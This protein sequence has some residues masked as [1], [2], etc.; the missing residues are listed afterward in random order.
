[1]PKSVRNALGVGLGGRI[2][3]RVEGNSVTLHAIPEDATQDPALT[4]FLSLLAAD[5]AA[6]PGL[7]IRP[8]PEK[9]ISRMEIL[10]KG[11]AALDLDAPIE[12]DVPLKKAR[13]FWDVTAGAY[14]HIS[15]F[16]IS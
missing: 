4:P 6:R 13:Q 7:A 9:Q 15:C 5:L 8:L 16:W 2:A 14:M 12:G 1:M 3:Y 11:L 10:A